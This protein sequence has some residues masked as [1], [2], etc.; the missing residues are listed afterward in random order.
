M[1]KSL[2]RNPIGLTGLIIVALVVLVALVAPLISPYTPTVQIGRRLQLPSARFLLGTDEFGRDILSRIIYGTRI[3]LYVGAISVGLALLIGGTIGLVSGYFGGLLDNLLMRL[4]DI[5]FSIP[6]LIL[7]IAIA[8]LLGPNLRNAMIA[9]GI[10][11]APT[12]ARLVRAAVLA[13]KN[14]PYIEAATLIGG[15]TWHTI[16]RHLIPNIS[17]PLIVQTSLLLSTAILAEAS[18]SFLG[19]GT[20]PPDPSWGTMLG[21]GRKFMELSPWVA[22]APGIA[23]VITVLG[24][25]FLGDGLRD[26]LD[27]RLRGGT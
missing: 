10:V 11:Y 13:I 23:I 16:T 4:V 24:F 1:L 14:L 17:P 6:S 3:S 9:I 5:V 2:R 18:L 7:A 15:S 25:N 19:L 26:V 27:P 22:V 20:Q 21:S 12:Y 8:G